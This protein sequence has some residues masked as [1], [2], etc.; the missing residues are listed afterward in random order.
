MLRDPVPR[1]ISHY[2]MVTSSDGTPA[3]LKTRGVEWR[4]KTF[5]QVVILE[6]EK[7][8]DCGL[9]PYWNIQEGVMDKRVFDEF[10]NGP[11]EDQAWSRYLEKHI[12]LNTGSYGLLTRGMY[13]LQLRPWFR[14]FE[15]EQFLVLRL[16]SMKKTNGGVEET[17][18]KVWARLD[19]P[20][21]PVL[22]ETP[23]NTRDYK[24]MDVTVKGYLE[25]FFEPHNR[26]LAKL[27]GDDDDDEEWKDPWPYD[28]A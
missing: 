16:E 17:M 24:P 22:D 4:K 20:N 18:R 6:L 7:M 21:H 9:I 27:L 14:A 12:P 23:K 2:A 5:W 28:A 25:R 3:Q 1:A 15:R 13:A 19:L 8:N 26:R 10:C 11:Q